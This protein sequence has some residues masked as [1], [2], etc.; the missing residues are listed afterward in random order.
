[1]QTL[2]NFLLRFNALL[3]FVF[4]QILSL[5]WYFSYSNTKQKAAFLT[6]ANTTIGNLYET[7]SK[8]LSYWNLAAVNDSLARE[9]ARLKMQLPQALYDNLLDTGRRADSTY[10]QQYRYTA[11]MVIHNSIARGNNN[12]TINRGSLHGV[13]AN[14]GL[15]DGLNHGVVGIVRSVSPHYASVMS[16]LHKDV[17]ISAKLKRNNHFGVLTWEGQDSRILRLDA[18][19]K[20]AEIEKGDTVITSGFSTLFPEGI[21]VGRVDTFFIEAGS[22]FYTAR[23]KLFNDLS[24][25]QHVHVVD[26]LFY[27]ERLKIQ[28]GLE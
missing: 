10:K 15:I 17:R 5:Y 2:L 26:D 13:R 21:L 27:E 9:N 25:V 8:L 24:R 23:I 22:N 3:A 19:P 4:F 11:A 16:V 20:H 12:L 6:S 1:M 14:T 28:G 7:H 18:L